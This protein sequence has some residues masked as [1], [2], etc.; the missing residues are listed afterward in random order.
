MSKK[1]IGTKSIDGPL[2]LLPPCTPPSS[3]SNDVAKESIH[4]M[5]ILHLDR[6]SGEK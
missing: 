6:L 1:L 5:T 3:S 2:F 4:H